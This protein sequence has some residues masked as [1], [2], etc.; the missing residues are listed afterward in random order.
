MSWITERYTRV[1]NLYPQ[2]FQKRFGDEMPAVFS[3]AL[4]DAHRR[5]FLALIGFYL[6]E[7]TSLPASIAGEYIREIKSG[8]GSLSPHPA[9][10]GAG[11]SDI[12]FDPG[13]PTSS[14][15]EAFLAGLPHVMLGDP[16][17]STAGPDRPG[18]ADDR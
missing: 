12:S 8:E 15:S 5:G 2:R 11:S 18:F 6:K 7:I 10:S 14:W 1:M 3:A 13:L 4:A 17:G 9:A 16:H